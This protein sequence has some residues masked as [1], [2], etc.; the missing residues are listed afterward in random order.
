[1][2][3]GT[4]FSSLIKR[5]TMKK[6][7]P[8][9]ILLTTIVACNTAKQEDRVQ[10]ATKTETE[11][12]MATE[13]KYSPDMVSNRMDPAC[14]MPVTAGINDTTHYNGKVLGFCSEECKETFQKDPATLIAKAD[15]KD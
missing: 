6:L 3:D 10:D 2:A 11:T 13:A 1:M 7:F 15:L 5:K 12:T 8:V 4:V 9:I 14:G